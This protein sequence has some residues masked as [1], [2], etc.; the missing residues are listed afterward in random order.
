MPQAV[1]E[2]RLTPGRTGFIQ[3]SGLQLDARS[4]AS[5][6]NEGKEDT[7]TRRGKRSGWPVLLPEVEPLGGFGKGGGWGKEVGDK[8]PKNEG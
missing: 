5:N 1:P 3:N 7:Q 4:C 6:R 2:N 8:V